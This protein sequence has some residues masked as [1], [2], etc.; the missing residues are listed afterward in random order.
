MV[1]AVSFDPVSSEEATIEV[2]TVANAVVP[3]PKLEGNDSNLVVLAK[4]AFGKENPEAPP[5]TPRGMP[6]PVA[7]PEG[8]T[9]TEVLVSVSTKMP[10][11]ETKGIPLREALA[12]L[13]SEGVK[14][15]VQTVDIETGISKAPTDMREGLGLTS[16]GS[17]GSSQEAVAE[18]ELGKQGQA[19]KGGNQPSSDGSSEAM[20]RRAPVQALKV[21]ELLDRP[22]D[23]KPQEANKAVLEPPVM[24][25][26]L[27]MPHREMPRVPTEMSPSQQTFEPASSIS[28]HSGT[29]Q[30]ASEI[31]E[32]P[33]PRELA[34]RDSMAD[35]AVKSVRYLVSEGEKSLRVRLVP[36]SLGEIRVEI[37]SVRDELH[38]RLVSG[39]ASVR[40]AMEK[41]SETLRSALA[42]DGVNIIR[43]TVAPDG[44]PSEGYGSF[45]GK[46]P[47]DGQ[48]PYASRHGESW[49][50]SY[51]SGATASD[52]RSSPRAY[53]EGLLSLYA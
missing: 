23:G 21:E 33:A 16:A 14:L 29:P 36:E 46:S 49:N 40:E 31:P 44:G 13:T 51:G 35:L 47:A 48:P 32:Y 7:K 53:H 17:N 5:P 37:V 9:E 2:K 27:D 3:A 6:P 24:R 34:F 18:L 25:N 45:S 1:A 10:T 26:V 28:Q 19:S 43:V 39:N 11:G 15:K 42:R 4:T 20:L 41:G 8:N 12:Y 50:K 38:L 30:A 52:E 22:L